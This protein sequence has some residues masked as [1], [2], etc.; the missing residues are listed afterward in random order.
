[1]VVPPNNWFHQHFNTGPGPARYLALRFSGRKF[2]QST[3]NASDDSDVSV[4]EGGKQIEYEDE[5][6]AI[7]ELFESELARHG[8]TC[9]MRG[10]VAWCT[11]EV[12]PTRAV[13]EK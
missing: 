4:T 1:V 8:A 10:L 9:R 11:G 12:G 3:N 6:R 7:H 13:A 2:I 5:A